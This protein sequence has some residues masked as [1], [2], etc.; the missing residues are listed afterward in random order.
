MLIFIFCGYGHVNVTLL[1]KT[2]ID[3]QR[4]AALL[5]RYDICGLIAE[6]ILS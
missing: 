3:N 2:F 1:E 4:L 5:L 6:G